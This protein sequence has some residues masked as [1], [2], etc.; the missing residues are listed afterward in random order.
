LS[1]L[2]R[3]NTI[4]DN[5]GKQ[6]KYLYLVFDGETDDENLAKLYVYVLRKFEVID[7]LR[8][9]T[10]SDGNCTKILQEIMK[11]EN[12]IWFSTV[13]TLKCYD[14]LLIKDKTV[15]QTFFTKFKQAETFKGLNTEYFNPLELF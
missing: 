11:D 1:H 9:D 4:A 3:I 2:S 8:I 10:K 12:F 15:L 6:A 5:I 14:G 7:T 13:K